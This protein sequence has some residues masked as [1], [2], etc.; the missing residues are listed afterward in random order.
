LQANKKELDCHLIIILNSLQA[1][2]L[3]FL[4]IAQNQKKQKRNNNNHISLPSI[5]ND[6]TQSSY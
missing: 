6:E 3:R 1:I 4:V 5:V 2:N